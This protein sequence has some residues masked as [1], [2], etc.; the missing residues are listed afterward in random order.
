MALS[1]LEVMGALRGA[2]WN[3]ERSR[4]FRRAGGLVAQEVDRS[5]EPLVLDDSHQTIAA[6][7][8]A[9]RTHVDQHRSHPGVITLSGETILAGSTPETLG[10]AVPAETWN[11]D[12]RGDR[13]DT[14]RDRVAL[15]T[16]GA[17]GFGLE[18]A[19]GLLNAGALVVLADRN[20]DGA[21]RQAA[22]LNALHKRECAVGAAVDVTDEHS[23]QEMVEQVVNTYGGIDLVISNAGVLKAGSV[24]ELSVQDFQFVTAVNYT[25]FFVVTR[26]VTPLLAAQNA[27]AREAGAPAWSGDIIEINSKSGLAGSNKNSAYAGSK[28]GG[29]GLVQSFALELVE[30]NIKVNAI[31][32]GNFLDGPLWSDRE[33]GLF[34]QYLRA[35]KVPG[36]KT[37]ED[38]RRSYE[39]RVPMK[40]GCTGQDVVRAILYVVEQRYET[41]QAVPVTGGQEMLR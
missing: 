30:H 17:Q 18:I 22:E 40:R 34:V 4:I 19:R 26:A 9:Y 28:F 39:E 16:G 1:F 15:V 3:G 10:E 13:R 31:C 36:A 5:G 14:V 6:I 27:G 35:G 7:A 32:P 11:A 23:V 38:V 20:V 37:L 8:H 12:A 21:R 25:G 2:S 33:N 24:T 29:I 41:G